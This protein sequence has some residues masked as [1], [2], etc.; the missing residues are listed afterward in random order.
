MHRV[1]D[2]RLIRQRP[3][4]VQQRPAKVIDLEVRRAERLERLLQ[5]VQKPVRPDAA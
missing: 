2:L 5:H 4:P 1:N 3:A